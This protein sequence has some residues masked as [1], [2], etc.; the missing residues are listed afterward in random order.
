MQK[1]LFSQRKSL[2]SLK[3]MVLDKEQVSKITNKSSQNVNSQ[4]S[5][6]KEV[7]QMCLYAI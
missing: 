5:S 4:I 3:P 6:G 1:I 7:N 2:V